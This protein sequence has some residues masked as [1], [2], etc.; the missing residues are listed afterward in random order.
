MAS[1]ITEAIDQLDKV[2]D[3]IEN[4]FRRATNP[5]SSCYGRV[6]MS[7]NAQAQLRIL[8]QR[9]A[10]LNAKIRRMALS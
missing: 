3:E 2:E 9:Q 4:L 6:P 1:E 5:Y 7:S 8:R 10:S